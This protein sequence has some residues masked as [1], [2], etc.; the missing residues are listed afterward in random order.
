MTV[1]WRELVRPGSAAR[2]HREPIQL[3]NSPIAG[4]RHVAVG[5]VLTSAHGFGSYAARDSRSSHTL[6]IA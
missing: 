2:G 5:V 3:Q 1:P 4:A 6:R